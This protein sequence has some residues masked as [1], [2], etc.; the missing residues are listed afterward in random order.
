MSAFSTRVL[1]LAL[2][3]LVATVVAGALTWSVLASNRL[4]DGPADL[5][6]DKAA[7]AACGMH[8]GE[9]AFAA[10]AI[11]KDGRVHAFDDPGCLLLWIAEQ[12]PDLH[13]MHFRHHAEARWI[14]AARTGFIAMDKTPM[15]FGLA[16]VDLGTASAIDVDAA[17]EKCLARAGGHGGGR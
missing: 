12:R 6:Y 4:P 2:L 11:T 13:S 5:V 8:V 7:C 17:K 15:G 10:Q 1:P 3:G 9:P 14:P 16:A